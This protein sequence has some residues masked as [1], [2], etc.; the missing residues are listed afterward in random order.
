MRAGTLRDVIA[1]ERATNIAD[2][3]SNEPIKSWGPWRE[4]SCAVQAKRGR[5]FFEAGQRY[6]ETVTR[7]TCRFFEIQGVTEK[8]SIMFNGNRYDIKAILPDYETRDGAVIEGTLV[9]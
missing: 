1:I 5:E 9:Q 3:N 2:P 7:F 4:V 6:A 8:D